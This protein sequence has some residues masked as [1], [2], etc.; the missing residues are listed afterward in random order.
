MTSQVT[1][2]RHYA[3]GDSA[4]WRLLRPKDCS[5]FHAEWYVSKW[6]V[7]G[8]HSAD[9][10]DSQKRQTKDAA[11]YTHLRS[12]LGEEIQIIAS[13]LDKSARTSL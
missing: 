2:D 13:S 6:L 1:S 7:S 12:I 4:H 10:T 5:A 9:D 8:R 11:D 3:L